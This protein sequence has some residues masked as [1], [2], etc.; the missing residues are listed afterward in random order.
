MSGMSKI[1]KTVTR[2]VAPFIIA[3]GIYIALTGHLTPGG[4]FP[5]GVI[6]AGCFILLTLAFGKEKVDG[7]FDTGAAE[8]TDSIASLSFLC[9]GFLGYVFG[10]AFLS[11]FIQSGFPGEPFGLL[12]G[13][14]MPI[15]NLA[16]GFKVGGSIF[17][18]FA[19]LA[20]FRAI[21]ED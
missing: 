20:T 3:F 16:I 7:V 4:G 14:N 12:S 17:M 5:G 10:G 13:G 6:I 19:F 15:I 9:M 1:V 8:I 2:W 11:N 18:V 21:E